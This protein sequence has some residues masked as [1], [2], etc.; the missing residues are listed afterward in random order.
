MAFK[1]NYNQ[2]RS[3]RTRAKNLKKQEKLQRRQGESDNPEEQSGEQ[4]ITNSE[5]ETS[6]RGDNLG[7]QETSSG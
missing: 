5:A 6:E 3:E 7:S 2:Q 4:Q 1:P